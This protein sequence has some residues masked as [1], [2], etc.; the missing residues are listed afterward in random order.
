MAGDSK[1]EM[2]SELETLLDTMHTQGASDM[3]LRSGTPPVLRIDGTLKTEASALLDE[4]M[5]EQML[6][7]AMPDD[8]QRAFTAGDEVDFAVS[9]RTGERFRVNAFRERAGVAASFRAVA[10]HPPTM[11]ALGLPDVLKRMCTLPSGIL[12][13]TGATGSGKST[14]LAA[15][16]NEINRARPVHILTLEDPIEYLHESARALVTQRQIGRDSKRFA[17]ALRAALRE[18]P[19]VILVGEL[20]DLETIS[21][22][23]TAAETGHLVFASLHAASAAKT[24]DRIIDAAPAQAKNEIRSMLSESLRAVVSQVLLPG[25]QG[26]R[27]AALEILVVTRAIANLIRED[28]VAQI[29]SAMQSGA[30][31]G[32]NTLDQAL[33]SLVRERR[34]DLEVARSAARF[35]ESLSM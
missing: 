3:H 25:S 24:V 12:L 10:S 4:L 8:V 32:M 6:A 21:L 34:V 17:Q 19:D 29:Y 30:A 27:V 11:D 5:L 28:R 7:S 35:P 15:M 2:N 13:V 16:I 23:L 20:R 26:G 22:A 31:H 14:T 18:D 33:K 1:P 9:S